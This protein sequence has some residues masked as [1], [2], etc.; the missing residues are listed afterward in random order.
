ML[1]PYAVQG[2]IG[3]MKHQVVKVITIVNNNLFR[4]SHVLYSVYLT[5]MSIFFT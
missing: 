5:I 3:M 2:H 1:D 4:T